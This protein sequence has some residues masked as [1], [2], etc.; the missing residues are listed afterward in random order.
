MLLMPSHGLRRRQLMRA[1]GLILT[2]AAEFFERLFTML[3][4][5]RFVPS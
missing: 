2:T 3:V 5:K 4:P 1:V